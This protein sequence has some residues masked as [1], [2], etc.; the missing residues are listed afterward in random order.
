MLENQEKTLEKCKQ[1]KT[2]ILHLTDEILNEDLSAEQ[3]A[4]LIDA[5]TELLLNATQFE[6]LVNRTIK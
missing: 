1:L 3:K 2:M 5:K 4:Q 6:V